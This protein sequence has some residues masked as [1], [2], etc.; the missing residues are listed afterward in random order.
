MAWKLLGTGGC[1]VSMNERLLLSASPTSANLLC[2]HPPATSLSSIMHNWATQNFFPLYSRRPSGFDSE[3][4]AAA[5]V[6]L[7]HRRW[8]RRSFGSCCHRECFHL[9]ESLIHVCALHCSVFSLWIFMLFASK[10]VQFYCNCHPDCRVHVLI[11][12]CISV[13]SSAFCTAPAPCP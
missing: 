10:A 2:L 7:A 3:P 11:Y 9:N 8:T 5:T 1:W 12:V 13:S 6:F 4:S